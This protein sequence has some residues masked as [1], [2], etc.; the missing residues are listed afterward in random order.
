MAI[1]STAR[2]AAS[3]PQNWRRIIGARFD[4][5]PIQTIENI[6]EFIQT[7]SAY[8]AQTS[9]Y[10]Y[11][12]T[13]MGTRYRAIF[14][15]DAF[16]PSINNAKWRTYGACL[17]DLT[18]FS[19]AMSGAEKR[20]ENDQ[21]E[22][23]ARHCFEAA[24]AHT[25]NDELARELRAGVVDAFNR[26][27]GETAWPNAAVGE[28]A[29]T[30]SAT[31]LLD[32]APIADELKRHDEEIVTNSIRFRWRDV[33]EQLRKRIDRDAI[34]ADWLRMNAGTGPSGTITRSDAGDR[35]R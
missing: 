24:V 6:T 34:C 2:I 15:D 21:I 18:V 32:S 28:N 26:R 20:L 33:R 12:K 11:L 31:E 5:S 35:G 17:S 8:V 10:G 7:R 13:R 23:L 29:F 14:E 25:F 27:I 19:A 16:A 9:L 22:A 3:L 4:K 30:H 1:F